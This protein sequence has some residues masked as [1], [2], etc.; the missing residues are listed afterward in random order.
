M[1]KEAGRVKITV[2]KRFDTKEVFKVPPVKAKYSGPCPIFKEGQVFHIDDRM[3]S[4]FCPYAWDVIFGGVVTLK[5][6]GNFSDWYDEP[7]VAVVSCPDGLRPVI[8]KL[9]RK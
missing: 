6:N 3:P 1:N 4:G 2:L 9:E 5:S 8:F 7:G